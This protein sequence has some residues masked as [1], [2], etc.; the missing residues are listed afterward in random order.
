M[1]LSVNK[2][3]VLSGTDNILSRTNDFLSR[4]NN[5]LSRTN[6]FLSRTKNFLSRTDNVLS[7]TKDVLD[8]TLSVLAQF[9]Y[10]TGNLCLERT[11]NTFGTA[12]LSYTNALKLSVMYF[13]CSS[14]SSVCI[15]ND[16]TQA[17][18]CSATGKSPGL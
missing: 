5:V 8:R 17:E 10:I 12:S 6:D 7:R 9:C 15:G 18:S 4:T 1:K 13:N 2:E 3:A 14:S 16:S 11:K